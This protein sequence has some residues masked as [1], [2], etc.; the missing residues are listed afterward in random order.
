MNLQVWL[1][2]MFLLG[3]ALMSFCLWFIKACEKI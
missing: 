1:P 2:A 3:I